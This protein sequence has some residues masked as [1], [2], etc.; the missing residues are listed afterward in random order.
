MLYS[1]ANRGAWLAGGGTSSPPF[2]TLVPAARQ[3]MLPLVAFESLR[4]A[5]LHWAPLPGGAER[6]ARKGRPRV[7]IR[8]QFFFSVF[9]S[10]VVQEDFVRPFVRD[11]SFTLF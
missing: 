1:C 6:V 2:A 9:G 10:L 5:L 8:G 11:S 4:F 7:V 3:K